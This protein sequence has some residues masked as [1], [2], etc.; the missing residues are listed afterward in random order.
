M[1][2][3]INLYVDRENIEIA[4]ARGINLS[5]LFNEVLI[6]EIELSD[7]TQAITPD[8][9]INKLKAKIGL[10]SSTIQEQ[11]KEIKKLQKEI[12]DMKESGRVT[13][14]K[15]ISYLYKKN[16]KNNI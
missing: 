1:K 3:I 7:V 2:G 14:G 9:I 11:N 6:T 4:K 16:E 8:E 12:K 13:R 5:K 10:L 15:D